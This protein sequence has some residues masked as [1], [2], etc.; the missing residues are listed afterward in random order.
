MI[1]GA[2]RHLRRGDGG[3]CLDHSAARATGCGCLLCLGKWYKHLIASSG[4]ALGQ[5]HGIE[6]FMEEL[7]SEYLSERPKDVGDSLAVRGARML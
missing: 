5:K 7:V 6:Q 2:S 3:Q 1:L 4:P